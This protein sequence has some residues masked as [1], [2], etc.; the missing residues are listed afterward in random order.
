M[1]TERN[2]KCVA[3]VICEMGWGQSNFEWSSDS[4]YPKG[5]LEAK[6]RHVV[7]FDLGK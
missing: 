3:H 7:L 6:R 1:L 5:L 4:E 2:E